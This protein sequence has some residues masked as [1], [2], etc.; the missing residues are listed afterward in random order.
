MHTATAQAGVK[1]G[2]LYQGHF[3]AN[4]YNY[5]EVRYVCRQTAHILTVFY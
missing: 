2:Q 3:N 4:Q 1:A 5:L